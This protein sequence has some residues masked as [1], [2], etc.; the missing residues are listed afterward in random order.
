MAYGGD[1]VILCNPM[2]VLDRHLSIVHRDHIPQRFEGVAETLL[3]LAYDL[4][5]DWFALYNGPECGASAPDHLHL[6]A[7]ARSLAPIEKSLRAGD[8]PAG[9]R[10]E[11][12][13]S[14]PRDEFELFTL[15]D[16]GRT[17]VVFRGND[18]DPLS[19]WVYEVVAELGGGT[20][21]PEPMINLIATHDG[22]LWTIFLFP[23]ARHRPACFF[24]EGEQRLI[25]S[26]GAIDMAGVLV[27]PE[28][29]HFDRIDADLVQQIYSE[30][31]L[32]EDL[33]NEA[34]ER[35]CERSGIEEAV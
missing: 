22:R 14:G 34:V 6:Q 1:F 12:C 9:E 35:V 2:P 25:V 29:E 13:E 8:A 26:P 30:V 4:G 18:P 27:L 16:C 23:R 5:P 28:R 15:T 31:S 21:R 11:I 33:V 20:S 17:A 19:R 32:S 3:A 10:C 7:C 24:A